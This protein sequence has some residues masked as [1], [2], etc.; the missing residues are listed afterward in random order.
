MQRIDF[1]LPLTVLRFGRVEPS[2]PF[3]LT[4]FVLAKGL[5]IVRAACADLLVVAPAAEQARHT[6]RRLRHEG[7]LDRRGFWPSK[8]A[9]VNGPLQLIEVE[10]VVDVESHS[11]NWHTDVCMRRLVDADGALIPGVVSMFRNAGN[12]HVA[13]EQLRIDLSRPG[14]MSFGVPDGAGASRPLATFVQ[15]T[16]QQG[17]S[18][19]VAELPNTSGTTVG[20]NTGGGLPDLAG[21]SPAARSQYLDLVNTINN[22]RHCDII[23]TIGVAKCVQAVG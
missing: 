21:M 6:A 23:N 17:Q 4:L 15:V 20:G 7:R 10:E 9:Q 13:Q 19:W 16:N 22:S 12:G 14:R 2:Q 8:P 5:F 1:P 11:S 3:A 18:S